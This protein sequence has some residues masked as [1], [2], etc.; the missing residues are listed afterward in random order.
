MLKYMSKQGRWSPLAWS[1]RVNYVVRAGWRVERGFAMPGRRGIRRG[2]VMVIEDF[3]RKNWGREVRQ[4]YELSAS[5][6]DDE[7]IMA[8][9]SQE[10]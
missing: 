6:S 1:W 7:D 9:F 5:I 8:D 10:W 2:L 3:Q 4:R